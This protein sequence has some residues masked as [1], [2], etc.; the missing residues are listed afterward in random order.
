MQR[1]KTSEGG[2]EGNQLHL[3]AWFLSSENQHLLQTNNSSVL[4]LF[5]F[6]GKVSLSLSQNGR[7][8]IRTRL[9]WARETQ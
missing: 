6:I 4:F 1:G 9:F 5:S 3:L 7:L 2:L 8:V